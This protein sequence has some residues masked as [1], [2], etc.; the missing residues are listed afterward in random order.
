MQE[1]GRPDEAVQP[2]RQA[3]EACRAGGERGGEARG[4]LELGSV[5]TDT[6]DH[7]GAVQAFVQ[8]MTLYQDLGDL[9]GLK[10]AMRALSATYG[11]LGDTA[12]AAELLF[13]A[14]L[15]QS[16]GGELVIRA[17]EEGNQR[18]GPWRRLRARFR[19]SGGGAQRRR[20][21]PPS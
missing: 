4:Y 17:D 15:L 14:G 16:G 2:L 5:L 13:F 9:A 3:I 20:R 11:R 8:A 21:T 7:T 10:T 6:A 18:V 19:R 12:R 1:V